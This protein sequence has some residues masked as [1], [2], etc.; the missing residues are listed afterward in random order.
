MKSLNLIYQR[1]S[2][3]AVSL[4][5]HSAPKNRE[6]FAIKKSYS[7][8]VSAHGKKNCRQRASRL[9]TCEWK[10]KK[11]KTHR[12][13]PSSAEHWSW[14]WK[15][16]AQQHADPIHDI[17]VH[18]HWI[19]TINCNVQ[20]RRNQRQADTQTVSSRI[21]ELTIDHNESGKRQIQVGA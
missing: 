7:I 1:G 13:K 16:A 9:G 18:W 2:T 5:S 20:R 15:N 12:K 11:I 6:M 21:N 10:Y 17:L 14:K 19:Q 3:M 8:E 4:A